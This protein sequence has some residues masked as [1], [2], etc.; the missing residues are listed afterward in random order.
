MSS[1]ALVYVD[2]T[3]HIVSSALVQSGYTTP[4]KVEDLVGTG[5]RIRIRKPTTGSF[6]VNVASATVGL[7]VLVL[8]TAA[9]AND[10]ATLDGLLSNPLDYCLQRKTPVDPTLIP[11]PALSTL[12]LDVSPAA[13]NAKIIQTQNNN[14]PSS[15]VLLFLVQHDTI[16]S[17][18]TA[19]PSTIP[20]GSPAPPALPVLQATDSV[21]LLVETQK[22]VLKTLT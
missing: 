15:L 16:D 11:T 3:K 17:S 12:G 7:K 14:G 4:P 10:R 20:I 22:L 9:F 19:L 18:P 6:A 2:A 13:A 1:L 21:C 5:P 8:D